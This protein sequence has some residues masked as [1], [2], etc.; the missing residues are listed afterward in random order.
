MSFSRYHIARWE[1]RAYLKGLKMVLHIT[2]EDEGR[3]CG[4]PPRLAHLRPGV[5]R[6]GQVVVEACTV[7]ILRV[8]HATNAVTT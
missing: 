5:M 2:L 7:E 6:Q 1:S 4:S 8:K 3:P